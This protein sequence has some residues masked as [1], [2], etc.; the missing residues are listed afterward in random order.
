MEVKGDRR[1]GVVLHD[2][3]DDPSNGIEGDLDM[4]KYYAERGRLQQ[5]DAT[6]EGTSTALLKASFCGHIDIVN[7]LLSAGAN[8][9]QA[10]ERGWTPLN[11]AAYKGHIE[12]VKSL[13]AAGANKDQA[14]IHGHTPL[15]TAA[16]KGHTEIVAVLEAA[17][18]ESQSI[19]GSSIA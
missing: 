16:E 15:D 4:A 13:L 8:K 10:N 14:N 6:L 1:S 5:V 12:C 2:L 11:T 7:A 18:A 3:M 9:D 17:A 19:D